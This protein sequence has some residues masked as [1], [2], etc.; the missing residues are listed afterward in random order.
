MTYTFSGLLFGY[1]YI[2]IFSNSCICAWCILGQK[3]SSTSH[4]IE[5]RLTYTK[6]SLCLRLCLTA[7]ASV[8]SRE[9]SNIKWIDFACSSYESSQISQV[10]KLP[11][12]VTN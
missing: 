10:R 5:N 7:V 2:T 12:N 6:A 11:H 8:G 9:V 3:Q 4:D 1:Q